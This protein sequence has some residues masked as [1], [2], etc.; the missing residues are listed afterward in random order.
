MIISPPFLPQSGQTSSDETDTDPM[1]TA[2]EAFEPGYHGVF[3]VTFDRRWHG[4]I[5]L[6]PDT[7]DEPVRAIADGEVVAYRVSQNPIS[8]GHI[9]DSTGQEA[10]NTNTGFVLLRHVTDTGDG[11]TITFYSL[12]MHLLDLTAQQSLAGQQPANSSQNTR[13]R[14]VRRGCSRRGMLS[15]RAT[16]KRFIARISSAIG[17]NRKACGTCTSKSS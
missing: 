10:L 13:P 1:M 2:V 16:A 9:D 11:R 8:D 3:P 14:R 5:H 17:G 4:G 12:Y 6:V 7:P 15:S